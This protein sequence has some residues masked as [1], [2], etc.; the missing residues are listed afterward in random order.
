MARLCTYHLHNFAGLRCLRDSIKLLQCSEATEGPEETVNSNISKRHIHFCYEILHDPNYHTD[1]YSFIEDKSC[2]QFLSHIGSEK[3]RRSQ[4]RA[5][6][7]RRPR[8]ACVE[9]AVAQSGVTF[10]CTSPS[11]R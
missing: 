10:R 7:G 6:Q 11:Q 3:L 1:C 9:A 5:E 4:K 2:F 8:R